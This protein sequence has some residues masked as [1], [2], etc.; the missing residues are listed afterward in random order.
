MFPVRDDNPHFLT[1]YATYGLIAA[2]VAAWILLQGF[3]SEP[4]LSASVCRAQTA[5]WESA[6]P[7]TQSSRPCSFTAAG[8]T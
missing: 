7:G 3:G 5:C 2:N 8:F 4:V 6:R 1:P